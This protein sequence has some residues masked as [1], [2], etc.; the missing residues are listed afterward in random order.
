MRS[1]SE[2]V[3][4]AA[5]GRGMPVPYRACKLTRYLQDTLCPSGDIS[6]CLNQLL[7]LSIA[8]SVE[9]RVLCSGPACF[10]RH[11]M[12][13]A[14]LRLA[15]F[16]LGV[17]SFLAPF[18]VS[19]MTCLTLC[20]RQSLENFT[21]LVRVANMYASWVVELPAGSS[22]AD[23]GTDISILLCFCMDCPAAK[24]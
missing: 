4:A 9:C 3:W 5:H 23:I 11:L 13:G 20:Q 19:V 1:V 6:C 22:L 21:L 24:L 7:R 18:H 17:M 10:W 16:M 2:V 14:I 8:P 12:L 15:P